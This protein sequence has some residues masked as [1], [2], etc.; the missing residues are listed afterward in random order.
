VR[1]GDRGDSFG[2]GLLRR[3]AVGVVILAALG[4]VAGVVVREKS[5][6]MIRRGAFGSGSRN[7]LLLSVRTG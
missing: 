2:M 7:G 4:V 3:A 1:E 6:F 5:G